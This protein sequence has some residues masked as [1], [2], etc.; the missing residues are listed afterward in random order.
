MQAFPP[1]Q[2][3]PGNIALM[4]TLYSHCLS[5]FA[6]AA[7]LM[8]GAGSTLR[9]DLIATDDSVPVWMDGGGTAGNPAEY[10]LGNAPGYSTGYSGNS[11]VGYENSYNSLTVQ[12]GAAITSETFTIGWYDASDYN[13][14]TMTGGSTW[15]TEGNILAFGSSSSHNQMIVE[16]GSIVKAGELRINQYSTASNND[17]TISGTGSMVTSSRIMMGFAS[18]TTG[19]SITLED[20]GMMKLTESEFWRLSIA[21]DNYLKFDGG[22]FAWAG[23]QTN[24]NPFEIALNSG[25]ILAKTEGGWLEV[26]R[27]HMTLQYYA[28]D[29]AGLAATGIDGLGG[30]TVATAVPEP[31]TWALLGIA[32]V[33]LAFRRRFKGSLA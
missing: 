21:S 10:I 4:K 33:G 31:G 5:R 2:L 11:I 18:G 14:V 7:L 28:T 26:D 19:S 22:Y 17:L 3:K 23:D 15:D 24:S 13:T 29:A 32:A 30:Y 25:A 8:A 9:A 27:E 6:L 16:D 12:S 20:G 1:T